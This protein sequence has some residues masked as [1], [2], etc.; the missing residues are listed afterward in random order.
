M[1]VHNLVWDEQ[2]LDHIADHQVEWYEVEE[3][4]W[5]DSWFE[6]RRGRQRYHVYGQTDDGRYLF[7]VLDRTVNDDFYVVTARDM[8]DGERKYY[9]RV[10]RKR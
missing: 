6:N 8:D 4:V 1:R 10:K 7:I 3:T 9:R 2:N 5:D